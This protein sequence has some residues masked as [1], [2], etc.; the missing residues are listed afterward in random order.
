MDTPSLFLFATFTIPY[1]NE[2]YAF[3]IGR[4]MAVIFQLKNK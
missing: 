2:K 3:Q 4:Y 1:Q